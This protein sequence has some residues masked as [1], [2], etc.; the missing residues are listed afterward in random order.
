MAAY[1]IFAVIDRKPL[2]DSDDPNGIR[3]LDLRGDIEFS[4]VKFAF[5][6]R[7]ENMILKVL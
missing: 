3:N 2:F 5:P 4:N 1:A 7:P 6:S